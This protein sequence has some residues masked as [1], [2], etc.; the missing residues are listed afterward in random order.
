MA[1][2]SIL[3]RAK[4][5]R[6]QGRAK[7]GGAA[8]EETI[9]YP[10]TAT[11]LHFHDLP[12][13]RREPSITRI[14]SPRRPRTAGGSHTERRVLIKARPAAPGQKFEG[15]DPNYTFSTPPHSSIMYGS[16][17]GDA[18]EKVAI[19]MAIG[20]PSQA[21]SPLPP[22]PIEAYHNI[23][24]SA[25]SPPHTIDSIDHPISATG[26]DLLKQKGRWKMFGGIFGK[27]GASNPVSPASPNDYRRSPVS[28]GIHSGK[29]Q[30]QPQSRSQRDNEHPRN[31]SR[32]PSRSADGDRDGVKEKKMEKKPQTPRSRLGLKRTPTVQTVQV[33][34]R[35]SPLPTKDSLGYRNAGWQPNGERSMLLQVDIP[36]IHMERY[37]VM[38]GS[39]LPPKQ[40]SSLLARRQSKQ[41]KSTDEE[42]PKPSAAIPTIDYQ[43]HLA[44]PTW[45]TLD[46]KHLQ[47]ARSKTVTSPLRERSPSF[48]LFPTVP[49]SQSAIPSTQQNLKPTNLQRSVTAPGRSPMRPNFEMHIPSGKEKSEAV[50]VSLHSPAHSASQ[51]SASPPSSH[52]KWSSDFSSTSTNSSL[53]DESHPQFDSLTQK[54]S[55][56]DLK[57]V[58]SV[59]VQ[60][61][62]D[63]T[64]QNFKLSSPP[65]QRRLAQPRPRLEESPGRSQSPARRPP[66]PMSA[67]STPHSNPLKSLRS[68]PAQGPKSAPLFRPTEIPT[69]T[70]FQNIVLHSSSNHAHE[71]PPMSNGQTRPNP[72]SSSP[73]TD[74][75][76]S[77]ARQISVSRRQPQMLLP[78][79]P[80][81]VRQPMQARLV[82]VNPDSPRAA[83]AGERRKILRK[84]SY[85]VYDQGGEGE[86]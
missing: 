2:E 1:K 54:S 29:G 68:N 53:L 84:S 43:S 77:I 82:S 51:S 36:D 61:K 86:F 27:K 24:Y 25:S 4:S 33:E 21:Q 38:F 37:S 72:L 78:S 66:P 79:Q 18:S 81:T 73:P 34:E 12:A 74:D 6:S 41:L 44:Q 76:I 60:T 16:D 46:N 17:V 58:S 22:L 59:P 7:A 26:D 14:P 83:D 20:S 80:K 40:N 75:E 49:T 11:A 85:V 69:Q 50:V 39:L 42:P 63:T 70:S 62:P 64:L 45:P 30:W 28:A 5:F 48:S 13:L 65:R 31:F 3:S 52:A 55:L 56:T 67:Y 57:V 32:S 9:V 35:S 23:P 8:K 47:P 15:L 71:P 19:G 10:A